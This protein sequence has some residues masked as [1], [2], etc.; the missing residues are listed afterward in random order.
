MTP[1]QDN[2]FEGTKT[3][4]LCPKCNSELQIK[5]GSSGAFWTCV[6][7][8]ACDYTRALSQSSEVQTVKIL[9]DVCC[10]ECEGD[11]AVKAGKF[12]MF[13]GCLNYP[14]CNF[15]VK[16]DDD[17]DYEPV[18]CPLCNKGELHMRAN[19]KGKSFYACNKYPKCDYLVN[20]KPI[21]HT[22]EECDWSIMLEHNNELQCPNCNHH[23]QVESPAEQNEE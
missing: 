19:K 16:D 15:T 8:P 7:Y 23:F 13:I 4:E 20:H 2:P 11:L 17:D 12:G 21:L 10:P 3:K 6:T 22:C 18:A 9:D 1:D 14:D 5:S